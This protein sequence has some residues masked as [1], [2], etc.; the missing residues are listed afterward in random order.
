MQN[1]AEA[2]PSESAYYGRKG[3]GFR[4]SYGF[5]ALSRLAVPGRRRRIRAVRPLAWHAAELGPDAVLSALHL[6]NMWRLSRALTTRPSFPTPLP[7]LMCQTHQ[8]GSDLLLHASALGPKN[9]FHSPISFFLQFIETS[10]RRKEGK[11]ARP[12]AAHLSSHP[13]QPG[14]PGRPCPPP[15]PR[16]PGCPAAVQYAQVISPTPSLRLRPRVHFPQLSCSSEDFFGWIIFI[17][18]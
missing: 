10:G 17:A 2:I 1:G 15:R 9:V 4:K 14:P 13:R 18:Q 8:S 11:Q 6:V 3:R 16:P 5:I 12:H 7:A